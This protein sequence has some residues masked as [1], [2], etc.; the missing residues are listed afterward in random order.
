MTCQIIQ[1]QTKES[2]KKKSEKHYFLYKNTWLSAKTHNLKL[3]NSRENTS[4]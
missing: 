3:Y 2:G 1:I 4:V